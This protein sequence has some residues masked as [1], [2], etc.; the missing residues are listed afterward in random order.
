MQLLSR[1]QENAIV[2]LT[3][4]YL[5]SMK[6]FEIFQKFDREDI[7]TSETFL[8]IARTVCQPSLP[9]A[10]AMVASSFSKLLRMSAQKLTDDSVTLLCFNSSNTSLELKRKIQIQPIQI[11]GL[12]QIL[13][14]NH[15]HL[16]SP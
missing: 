15:C 12:L 9:P 8:T 7:I 4:R 13:F 16:V 3:F 11:R 2:P 14:I 10:C 6:A 1:D 5:P